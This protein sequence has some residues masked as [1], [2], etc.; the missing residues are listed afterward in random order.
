MPNHFMRNHLTI[1]LIIFAV[2]ATCFEWQQ[3]DLT[4]AKTL[5]GWEGG[6]WALKDNWWFKEVFHTDARNL[7]SVFT[8]LVLITWLFSFMLKPLRVWR[9][10]LTYLVISILV[11]VIVIAVGKQ[12]SNVECPWGLS[13]FGGSQTYFPIFSEHMFSPSTSECFPAGHASAG[14]AWFGL[15][16]LLTKHAPRWRWWGLLSVVALGLFFGGIQQ[17]RGAHF[18]SHDLWTLGICWLVAVVCCPLLYRSEHRA[19]T[20]AAIQENLLHAS[21]SR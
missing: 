12:F 21:A 2:L 16:F 11:S 8:L 3:W 18:L 6:Q 5:Y 10:P 17:L 15:Y 20:A 1:P 9:R 14:Y 4:I 7:M 19:K 13:M